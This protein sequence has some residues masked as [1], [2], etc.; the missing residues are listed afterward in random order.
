MASAI[1]SASPLSGFSSMEEDWALDSSDNGSLISHQHDVVSSH[2]PG[3]PSFSINSHGSW[4][5]VND[6]QPQRMVQSPSPALPLDTNVSPAYTDPMH[7]GI[8]EALPRDFGNDQGT[9]DFGFSNT[10]LTA[11]QQI[12]LDQYLIGAHPQGQTFHM[13]HSYPLGATNAF[14]Q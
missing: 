7:F 1:L 13:A 8:T 4:V 5:F 14:G 2:G 12:P 10:S 3:S 9:P 6:Q 11:Q